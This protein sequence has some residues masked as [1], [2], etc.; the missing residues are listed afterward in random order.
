MRNC[1]IRLHLI[2]YAMLGLN[3]AAA[4]KAAPSVD[5][6]RR[7]LESHR[8]SPKLD[9]ERMVMDYFFGFMASE[10]FVYA[11]GPKKK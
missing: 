1:L 4:A 3:F 5:G 6:K 10:I 11:Y 8:A 9:E 2:L 7:L